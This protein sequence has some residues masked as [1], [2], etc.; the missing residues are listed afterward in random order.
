MIPLTA[1]LSAR[2]GRAFAAEGFADEFGAVH[3][4]DRPDLAQF[5]CNGALAAAKLAKANPRAIAEKIAARLKADPLFAKVE[6][7]G[8]GFINLDVTDSVLAQRLDAM[9]SDAGL[10]APQTGTGKTLVIDFGGPN[11]A[12]PMHVGHLRSAIIGDSLQKLFRAN[13]WH[14]VSDVHLGD[15][16][17]QMGQLISEID[18]RGI[19]P[20]Y[21]DANYSGPYP[22]SL[23]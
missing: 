17:L 9:A 23:R 4:S 3:V 2:A 16:G 13:G 19:A 14:V 20:I 22:T 5:Q 15:W 10:G 1:E 21:F 6:I 11:V 7:A 12:K 18:H 8:P